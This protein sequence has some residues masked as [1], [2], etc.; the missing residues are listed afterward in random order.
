MS[1]GARRQLNET[2]RTLEKHREKHKRKQLSLMSSTMC[3]LPEVPPCLMKDVCPLSGHNITGPSQSHYRTIIRSSLS[4]HKS[5]SPH[6]H[7]KSKYKITI[8]FWSGYKA[9]PPPTPSKYK[10]TSFS[11]LGHRQVTKS[12][13]LARL[14]RHETLPD[15]Q[16]DYS[17]TR[18]S[19]PYYLV[20]RHSRL[21]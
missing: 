6:P 10:T 4:G 5:K 16:S 20:E 8:L 1:T 13:D 11:L 9:P 2:K 17:V 15:A 19:Q 14:Q 21:D 7:P 12:Y 3:W 18:H